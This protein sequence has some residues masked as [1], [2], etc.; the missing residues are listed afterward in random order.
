MEDHLLPR[1]LGPRAIRVQSTPQRVP[2]Q[3]LALTLVRRRQR[4]DAFVVFRSQLAQFRLEARDFFVTG[5]G[6]ALGLEGQGGEGRTR[7]REASFEGGVGRQELFDLPSLLA[8]LPYPPVQLFGQFHHVLLLLL[9]NSLLGAQIHLVSLHL[10]PQFRHRLQ[11]LFPGKG[12]VLFFHFHEAALRQGLGTSRGRTGGERDIPP[13]ASGPR[14]APRA[15]SPSA[16]R[17]GGGRGGA[18]APVVG[19]LV[20]VNDGAADAAR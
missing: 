2:P 17:F 7:R 8:T 6:V 15:G 14:A 11:E 1:P 3:F 4:G 13:A 10:V 12:R 19:D 5:T 18:V 20:A 16:A 9:S